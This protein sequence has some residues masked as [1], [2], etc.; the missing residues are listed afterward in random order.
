VPEKLTERLSASQIGLLRRIALGH[1]LPNVAGAIDDNQVLWDNGLLAVEN[2][3]T[4]QAW[5]Y[6]TDRGREVLRDA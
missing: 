5:P 6:L 2:A 1:R 4:P 3:G